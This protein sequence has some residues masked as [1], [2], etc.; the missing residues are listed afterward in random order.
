MNLRDKLKTNAREHFKMLRGELQSLH[1]PEWDIT[2]FYRPMTLKEQSQVLGLVD[3]RKYDEAMAM[4]MIFMVRDEEGNRLFNANEK[5][6]ICRH[7]SPKVVQRVCNE[8]DPDEG[9]MDEPEKN[10]EPIQN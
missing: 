9:I 5:S 7:Y 4:K 1:V 6:D 8:M 2:V 3:Q 10:S